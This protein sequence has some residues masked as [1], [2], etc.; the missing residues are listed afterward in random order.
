MLK[1]KNDG[2][3][4]RKLL[5]GAKAQKLKNKPKVVLLDE[6]KA[7][8]S[9][10]CSANLHHHFSGGQRV[11]GH[12]VLFQAQVFDDELLAVGRILARVVSEYTCWM[13]R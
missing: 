7:A 8:N 5:T 6:P 4:L 2:E 11:A 12:E 9:F 3:E 10:V 13:L 1:I